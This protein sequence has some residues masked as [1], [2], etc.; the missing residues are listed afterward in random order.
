MPFIND[1]HLASSQGSPTAT[2]SL[3]RIHTGPSRL[4]FHLCRT[5]SSEPALISFR[6]I[7]LTW[8]SSCRGLFAFRFDALRRELV[9]Q[10]AVGG[11]PEESWV[12]ILFHENV[13]AVLC[14]I[15]AGRGG[16]LQI[17][18]SDVSSLI[19]DVNLKL[20]SKWIRTST[21]SNLKMIYSES[22]HYLSRSFTS[23]KL[24]V[25]PRGFGW[26]L[27]S[28]FCVFVIFAGQVEG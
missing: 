21:T 1:T 25:Y 14:H 3:L 28:W 19:I 15:E 8:R 18:L 12:A 13:D 2:N 5:T 4:S 11:R 10:V 23:D 7:F 27:E 17:G 26:Q 20:N 6:F 9:D 16:A 24:L 22:F